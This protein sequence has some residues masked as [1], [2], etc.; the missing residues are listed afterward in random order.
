MGLF[1][2]AKIHAIALNTFREAIRNKVLYAVLFFAVLLIMSSLALGELSLYEQER[3]VKDVGLVTVTF[4]SVLIAI[5]T[6][7]SLLYKEIEKKTIYTIIPKPIERWQFLLGKFGGILMTMAVQLLVMS[8][9]LVGLLLVRDIALTGTLITALCL[10]FVEVSIIAAVAIFFSAF[11][12]PLVSGMLT[13]M[14][15]LVGNLYTGISDIVES[16]ESPLLA[17]ALRISLWLFP[18]LTLFNLSTAVTYNVSVSFG[19]VSYA[20]LYGVAYT[21]AVLFG[22]ILVFERRDFI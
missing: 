7:V 16:S 9:I 17:A 1:M 19:A 10:I 20:C 15:F 4:F 2:L 14:V 18:D 6:G 11:S 12:T 21:A 3:V 13:A 22:S 5:Y 8:A